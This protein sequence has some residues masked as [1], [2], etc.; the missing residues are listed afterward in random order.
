MRKKAWAH[1]IIE[2]EICRARQRVE[3]SRPH[4]KAVKMHNEVNKLVEKHKN[5]RLHVYSNLR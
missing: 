5:A 2:Y 4:A 1:H 3:K